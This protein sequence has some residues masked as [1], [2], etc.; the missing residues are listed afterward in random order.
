MR[1][2]AYVENDDYVTITEK[3]ILEDYYDEDGF[4]SKEIIIKAFC[5][6]HN[7]EEIEL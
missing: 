1:T 5:D 2:F 7:A 6:F 3:E 4:V